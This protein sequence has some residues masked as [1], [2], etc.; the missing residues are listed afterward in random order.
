M[1]AKMKPKP[2]WL[3]KKITPSLYKNL[4]SMLSDNQVNTVCQEA[5]CPNISECFAKKEA[6]FMILG[7]ICTRA[8]SFCAVDRGKPKALDEEALK[9]IANSNAKINSSFLSLKKPSKLLFY[10]RF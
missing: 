7:T 2:E 5:Q 9:L 4:E 1:Q 3:R 8:C 6:T 10:A